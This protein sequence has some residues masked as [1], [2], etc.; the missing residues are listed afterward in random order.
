MS[1]V[2]TISASGGHSPS[3]SSFDTPYGV[4]G[5][6]S[7]S[8]VSARVPVPGKTTSLEMWTSRARAATAAAATARVPSTLTLGSSRR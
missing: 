2:R 4:I 8:S 1:D 3:A 5:P 7:S 6:G